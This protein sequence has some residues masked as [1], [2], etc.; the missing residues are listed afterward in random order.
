MNLDI[1]KDV[2]LNARISGPTSSEFLSG[3]EAAAVATRNSNH[4][5]SGA[6][7]KVNGLPRYK[8]IFSK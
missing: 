6:N 2:V 1:E 5:Y 3:P 4:L 7:M 8:T